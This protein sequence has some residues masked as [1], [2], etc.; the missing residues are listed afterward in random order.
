V[1][2]LDGDSRPDL[3][4]GR[5]VTNDQGTGLVDVALGVQGLANTAVTLS[6]AAPG[7]QF[8]AVIGR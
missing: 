6:G 2:D 8:G 1:R 3:L 7:D 4:V 5:L